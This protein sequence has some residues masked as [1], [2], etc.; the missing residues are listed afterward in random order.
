MRGRVAARSSPAAGRPGTPRLLKEIAGRKRWSAWCM[1]RSR[2]GDASIARAA[3]APARFSPGATG[4]ALAPGEAVLLAA[5]ARPSQAVLL[6]ASERPSQSVLLSG[7]GVA[8]RECAVV[9][10]RRW[11]RAVGVAPSEAI[12]LGTSAAELADECAPVRGARATR[13]GSRDR[14]S[15][16]A[17]SESTRRS[18]RAR[19]V[20]PR[21]RAGAARGG[22]RRTR[23]AA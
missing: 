6:A 19:R 7:G 18:A 23:A 22:T 10:D 16:R 3:R 13:P 12:L 9:G 4:G 14:A 11:N 2:Y 15:A 21:C 8:R 17:G 5:S 1:A 20:S